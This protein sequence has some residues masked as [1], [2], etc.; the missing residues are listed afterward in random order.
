MGSWRHFCGSPPGG[1][2]IGGPVEGVL[3]V[4]LGLPLSIIAAEAFGEVKRARL[5]GDL[6]GFLWGALVMRRSAA[7]RGVV[8][9]PER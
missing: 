6:I 3:P 1:A 5:K 8:S 4:V 2:A 9:S 7:K